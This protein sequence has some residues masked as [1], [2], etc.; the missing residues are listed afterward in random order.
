MIDI[1]AQFEDMLITPLAG[2]GPLS[3]TCAPIASTRSRGG[4]LGGQGS[5]LD[6]LPGFILVRRAL[7]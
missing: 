7:R 2:F 3:K 5:F 4:N 6:P 1:K